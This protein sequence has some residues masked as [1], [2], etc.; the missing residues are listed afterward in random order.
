MSNKIKD[1]I[2]SLAFV[3]SAEDK[4]KL[5]EIS[6][7]YS[8]SI[9]ENFALREENSKLKNELISKQIQIKEL[10]D[11]LEEKQKLEFLND[12]EKCGYFL[13]LE[14]GKV[15]PVCPTCYKKENIISILE[16][17]SNG[18][19]CPVCK[20]T[21]ANVKAVADGKYNYIW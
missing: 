9:A 5:A 16:R 1:L 4:K 7:A 21:F 6:N 15:G 14:Q 11:K 13:Q 17:A 2:T 3:L 8:A 20:N 19:Y 12:K 10:N 18:A